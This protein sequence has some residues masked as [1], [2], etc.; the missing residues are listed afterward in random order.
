MKLIS[1]TP[2]NGTAAISGN[3]VLFTPATNFV[4]AATIGYTITDNIGGTNASL[5]TVT[6]GNVTPIPLNVSLSGGQLTFTWSDS[7]FSLQSSTNVVG[8]YTTIVGATNPYVILATN[9][10][11]FY[12]LIH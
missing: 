3:Q 5:I 11:G 6:V 4:G 7:S 2:T 10:M 12:R 1:V 9:T 8:P